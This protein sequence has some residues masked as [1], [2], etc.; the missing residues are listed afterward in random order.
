MKLHR[1]FRRFCLMNALD[2]GGG[3]GGAI[4]TSVPAEVV[5][6][7]A[8]VV[9]D[10]PVVDAAA[11]KTMMEAMFPTGAEE[12]PQGQPRDEAGRFAAKVAAD[13]A[14]AALTGAKPAV[15]GAPVVP[16]A[17]PAPDDLKMPE[18]LKPESQQRFQSMANELRELR[19]LREQVD[20]L[21]RQITPIKESLV[22]N[23]VE[24][25]Q[26]QQAVGVIGMI[27]SGD[28]AGAMGVL[29]EQMQQLALLTG[30]P[31]AGAI[32]PLEKFPDLRA[33]VDGMQITEKHAI[34]LARGRWQQ[35]LV[36]QRTQQQRQQENT[37]VEQQRVVDGA[38]GQ[39]DQFVK[40]KAQTDIDYPVIEE[41]LLPQVQ[42][43]MATSRP[44]QW[45][46]LIETMYQT[47]KATTGRVRQSVPSTAGNMLRPS[48]ASSAQAA[49]RDGFE[50]MWN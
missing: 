34:E 37:Q 33:A 45:R 2:E 38:L 1:L 14:A 39:I 28:Y 48:G 13:A 41:I 18:G 50:A 27:N 24:P 8:A 10:T 15:P 17:K 4:D 19:P 49:P 26:F 30:E 22:H 35:G 21:E 12:V 31:A 36:E 43:I 20:T 7:D 32:D 25:V 5:A 6:P 42:Q 3:G 9:P 47:I 40:Q 44:E 46:G 16:A 23:K 29:R 11:P